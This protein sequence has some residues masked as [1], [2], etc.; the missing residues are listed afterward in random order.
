MT[1]AVS[2]DDGR[3]QSTSGRGRALEARNPGG[4]QPCRWARPSGVRARSAHPQRRGR[5]QAR[6]PGWR[7]AWARPRPQPRRG[8]GLST[9]GPCCE[10]VMA[11]SATSARGPTAA[12]P[13]RARSHPRAWA[14]PYGSARLRECGLN[15]T[16]ANAVQRLTVR[17]APAALHGCGLGGA[18]AGVRP[19]PPTTLLLASGQARALDPCSASAAQAQARMRC[20]VCC[21]RTAAVAGLSA[22]PAA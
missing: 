10:R 8:R 1:G 20:T 4:L 19:A 6:T 15:G 17:A 21:N 13:R 5:K 11:A 14:Q 12:Q 7:G 16:S 9:R 22:P 2:S 3:A 18:R